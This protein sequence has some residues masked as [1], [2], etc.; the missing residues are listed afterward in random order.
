MVSSK[1]IS[2]LPFSLQQH[3]LCSDFP[4]Q[5]CCL[6]VLTSSIVIF[7]EHLAERVK[8][9]LNVILFFRI[10]FLNAKDPLVLIEFI[11]TTSGFLFHCFNILDT[12]LLFWNCFIV[13][14]LI[15]FCFLKTPCLCKQSIFYLRQI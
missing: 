13:N 8:L 11:Y 2:F 3:I 9:G 6:L 7:L 15:S 14:S 1:K 12:I 5:F 10:E 4:S